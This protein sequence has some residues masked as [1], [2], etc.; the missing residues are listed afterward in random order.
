[1]IFKTL[2]MANI[3]SYENLTNIK[4]PLGTSLFEGDIGSGK[5]TILMAIEFALFGLGNQKGD[6][7]L[8]K[9]SKKGSVYLRFAVGDNDYQVKRSLIRNEND[10]SVRQD[11]GVFSV[12]GKKI[13]LSPSEIKEKILDILNFKEPLNPRSQSVI[14]RY[15]IYTPQEEMKYI[16]SQKPDLRLQTLRKA[17]G[18]EDYKIAAENATLI[19]RLI[20]Q[21]VS[22]LE[23]QTADITEK[24]NELL[25]LKEKK[26]GNEN[27]LTVFISNGEKLEAI[28]KQ[29]KEEVE[30]LQGL[31]LSLKEKKAEIPHLKKQIDDKN[32]LSH[33]YNNEIQAIN[34]E[35]QQRLIPQMVNLQTLKRPTRETEDSLSKKIVH[36]KGIVKKRE[37]LVA[38]LYLLNENVQSIENDLGKERN[39]TIDDLNTAKERLKSETEKQ[40]HLISF[41]EGEIKKVSGGIYQLEAKKTDIREKLENLN[42]IGDLCPICDSILDDEHKRNLMNERVEKIGKIESKIQILKEVETKGNEELQLQRMDLI[43]LQTNLEDLR[44]IMDKISRLNDLKDKLNI[45]RGDLKNLDEKLEIIIEETVEFE[46]VDDYLNHFQSILNQLKE[47]KKS[48]ED[49]LNIEYQ[50]EKNNY[51]IKENEQAIVVLQN[52]TKKLEVDLIQAEKKSVKLA[53]IEEKIDKLK[54][55]YEETAEKFKLITGNIVSTKTL[56]NSLKENISKV[57]DDISNKQ[58]LRKQL[59]RLK[60]YH[61]WLND[62]LIPTLSSIEKQVMRNI[63]QDFNINFQKWFGLLMDDP[64]KTGKIN[65]EFTPIVEQDGFEQDINYLSGG[66]KTSVALAYRL[67]LNN[68]VQKVSTGMK[69]N[70]LILDEPTDGFS[71]EQLFKVRD[72]L[73]ELDCPQIIIVSHERELESFADK[74]FR[75]EKVEGASEVIAMN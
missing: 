8:R 27:N 35:N 4:F 23:G 64:S 26:E 73:N 45:I 39:N 44:F 21:K 60:D 74:I 13:H 31:E 16:L 1:M 9:G 56:I 24:K 52:E 57:S 20:K 38:N 50:L 5:S 12:N 42:G 70:I 62:Y 53:N 36:L 28:L 61:I 72:I 67:A 65:E 7:L 22:F 41:Q 6:S 2:R 40:S 37:G 15:A 25:N 17:F 34:E 63:H 49:L 30:N 48:Q 66:E 32:Q 33:K 43:R 29:Q 47:F 11:K 3:R 54:L 59:N 19:S 68:I 69:S 14:F 18:I 58:E 10:G 51:R 55:G 71:K 75:I 46:H